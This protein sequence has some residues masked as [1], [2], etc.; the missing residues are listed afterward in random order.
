V[1]QTGKYTVF[2]LH[3]G[4]SIDNELIGI[5][6]M[7][8]DSHRKLWIAASNGLNRLDPATKTFVVYKN[9][10][11]KNFLQGVD[12]NHLM[13]SKEGKLWMSVRGNGFCSFDTVTKHFNWYRKISDQ[14]NDS[15]NNSV[16]CLME[17]HAGNIWGGAQS[18]GMF[19]F[20]P[21]TGK[22]FCLI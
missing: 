8:F 22:F 15:I 6:S 13:F 9:I 10:P 4:N 5:G 7:V 17:D 12:V 19:R 16:F 1:P 21:T 3:P 2:G 11:G 18:G 20:N 14:N